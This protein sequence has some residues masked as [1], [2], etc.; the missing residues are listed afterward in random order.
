MQNFVG[1]AKCI[2]G[3]M[4]VMDGYSAKAM[5]LEMADHHY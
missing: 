5:A 4:K 2:M 3:N 1:K